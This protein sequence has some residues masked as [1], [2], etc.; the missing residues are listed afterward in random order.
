MGKSKYAV[1]AE[2]RYTCGIYT[3]CR[4]AIEVGPARARIVWA[5]IEWVGST[6][7]LRRYVQYVTLERGERALRDY[8]AAIAADAD[9][10][11]YGPNP[12]DTIIGAVA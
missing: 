10:T 4:A 9:D 11:G 12:L 7:T 2:Y 3:D 6:G 8:R 1:A 5:A